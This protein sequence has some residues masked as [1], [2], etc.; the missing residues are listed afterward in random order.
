MGLQVCAAAD[1]SVRDWFPCCASRGTR[2]TIT[3]PRSN[4]GVCMKAFR[5]AS[6]LLS[7]PVVL[8]AQQPPANPI[9]TV[10]RGRT[11]GLQRTLAQAFDSIPESKF[12]YKPTPAQ[13]TIG[14]IAQHLV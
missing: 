4:P 10:F 9:T 13:L 7:V 11:L 6:L 12:G 1:R 8:A 3:S 5:L 2:P 14:H